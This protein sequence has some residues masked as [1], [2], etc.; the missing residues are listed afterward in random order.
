MIYAVLLVKQ[1]IRS[2]TPHV[3]KRSAHN[4]CYVVTYK[5]AYYYHH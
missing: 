3:L 5:V 1:P 4:R 2:V